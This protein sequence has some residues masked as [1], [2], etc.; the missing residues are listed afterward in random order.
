MSEHMDEDFLTLAGTLLNLLARR[1]WCL[2]T[3]ESLTGGMVA[4]S[5][6]AVP[7]ASASYLGGVVG[8]SDREKTVLLGVSAL[9]LEECGAVSAE[10]V[11]AMAR[12]CTERL[13]VQVGLATT[14]VAG[15]ASDD[16][17]TPVGTVF[18]ACATPRGC[19]M[20][21]LLL[22][23]NRRQ[24]RIESTRAALRLA[25]RFLEANQTVIEKER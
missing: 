1:G 12:G 25:V 11:E 5:I 8:Y 4:E 7:G 22:V 14:G 10:V 23:G 20:E 13:E 16:R 6:T 24:I 3:A 18:V 2:G 17:G 15:P 19:A 9:L 21:R